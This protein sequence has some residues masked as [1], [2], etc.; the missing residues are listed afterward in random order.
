MSR[1]CT[2]I[3]P[4]TDCTVYV[5]ACEGGHECG[6]DTTVGR[7]LRLMFGGEG[8]RERAVDYARWLARLLRRDCRVT[9]E[10]EGE[11]DD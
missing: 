11:S 6:V 9:L 3:P 5:E 8:T 10:F 2:S 1:C 4:G 7:R